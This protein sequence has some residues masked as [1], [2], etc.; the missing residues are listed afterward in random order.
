[1]IRECYVTADL[2]IVDFYRPLFSAFCDRICSV[3]N[4]GL[5]PQ[6]NRDIYF[7]GRAKRINIQRQSLFRAPTPRVTAFGVDW[8][9]ISNCYSHR[10]VKETRNSCKEK[11]AVHGRR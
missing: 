4:G 5:S 9:L 3:T 1:M 2:P 6:L 8:L 11:N 10:D 7:Y